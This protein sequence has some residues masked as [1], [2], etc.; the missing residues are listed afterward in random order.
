MKRNRHSKVS[1][2]GCAW[3]LAGTRNRERDCTVHQRVDQ[4]LLRCS[5]RH[6]ALAVNCAHLDIYLYRHCCRPQCCSATCV[7]DPRLHPNRSLR[8]KSRP[9]RRRQR[10]SP[11]S[12]AQERESQCKTPPLISRIRA[13]LARR[14]PC[15]GS[16]GAVIAKI[17]IVKTF[18]LSSVKIA[19]SSESCD[20]LP[21]PP[22]IMH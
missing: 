17:A 12:F 9:T 14:H 22:L 21:P 8:P 5:P 18:F 1:E 2:C 6:P 16:A 19:A 20:T 3:R 13:G 4:Q 10:E 11:K 15:Y 7:I